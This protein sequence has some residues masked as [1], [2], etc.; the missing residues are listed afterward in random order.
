EGDIALMRIGHILEHHSNGK[1]E[2]FCRIGGEEFVMLMVGSEA[3]G[4]LQRAECIRQCIEQE[5]I[6]HQVNPNGDRLTVSIG[7]AVDQVQARDLHFDKLYQ[8]A[9]VALYRA[10]AEGR[11]RVCSYQSLSV[12]A[13]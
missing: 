11:N 1:E 10:K 2:V 12:E 13:I 9:D 8:Q 3:S 5:Q 6:K 4:V 7:V